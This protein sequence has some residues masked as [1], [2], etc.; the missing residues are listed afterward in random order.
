MK[1]ADTFFNVIRVPMD[2]LMLFLAGLVTY[3]LRTELLSGLRPVLFQF[4][5][6][7]LT[8]LWLVSVASFVFMGIYAISGLYAMRVRMTKTDEFSR[9]FIGS[10]AGILLIIV[11][12]FLRQE[13][14]DSRFLVLGPWAFSIIL[15]SLGRLL[16]RYFQYIAVTKHNFG[17]Q[18]ALLIGEDFLTSQIKQNI[19]ATPSLGYRVVEHWQRTDVARLPRLKNVI[20]EVIFVSPNYSGNHITELVDFCHENHIVFKFV[21]NLYENLTT[22]FDVDMVSGVPVIELKRTP[23]DGW[24]KVFKR[25]IDILGSI[26]GLIVFSPVFLVVTTAVKLNTPGPIFVKLKRVSKNKEFELFKFRSMIDN[27]HILNP[28]LRLMRN[29]RPDAGPLWK[30][31]DDPRVTKVG[32]VIRKTRIDELPQ[33]WNVL[34]GDMSLV[35]PRPHQPDEIAQY[36]KHHKKLLAIKAGATGM[37]QVSGSS[38]IPFEEEVALD[39]FYIENWSLW[40]DLKIILKTAFKM[41]HDRSAV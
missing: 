18:R 6:P 10:S 39:S 1:K 5:L 15:V 29:D 28:Q 7:L 20:D 24:G 19:A 14:F 36:Q 25:T 23:L 30:L 27:A 34:K 8:Y 35:G 17:V 26:V 38:D 41:L 9:V 13:L 11:Y 2:F 21:P 22:H 32:K 16:V 40:L 12:I 31:K 4:N 33:L 3:L 37:A